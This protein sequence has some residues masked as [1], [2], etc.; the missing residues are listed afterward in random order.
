MSIA[1]MKNY[2]FYIQ[3][4]WA[5]AKKNFLFA[6]PNPLS[7]FFDVDL[8]AKQTL[9]ITLSVRPLLLQLAECAPTYCSSVEHLYLR[10]YRSCSHLF[11]SYFPSSPSLAIFPKR[12]WDSVPIKSW[13]KNLI[14]TEIRWHPHTHTYLTT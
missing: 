7:S 9:Q 8:G 12:C 10:A 13:V 14:E 4:L 5:G 2:I 1:K 11:Y 6:M 3:F